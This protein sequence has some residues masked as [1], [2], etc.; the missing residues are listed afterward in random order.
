MSWSLIVAAAVAGALTVLAPCIFSALP[1]ILGRGAD[2]Y[3]RARRVILGLLGSI[4]I[5]TFL[6]KVSTALLGIPLSFWQALSGSVIALVGITMFW[7]DIYTK[8]AVAL[9]LE[10][11]ANKSQQRA[12]ALE[13]AAG[14]YL[15]GASL[16][17]VFSACSPTYALIVAIILPN[18]IWEGTVYLLAFLAGLGLFLGLI[19]L[20][21]QKLVSRLG[22]SLDPKGKFKRGVGL[23]LII[24]GVLVATGLD[25]Q[26]LGWL[27]SNGW[28]DWQVRLEQVIR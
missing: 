21:G 9:R 7:P 15:L 2:G 23:L 24:V 6:L 22:W 11:S 10:A 17:P 26:L 1:L 16:G 20:G 18:N 13:G 28:Y 14:D 4:F 27:V 8:L 12:M 25:R 5:F 19:A 3:N